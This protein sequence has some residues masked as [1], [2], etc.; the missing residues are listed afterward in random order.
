MANHLQLVSSAATH[1]AQPDDAQGPPLGPRDEYSYRMGRILLG[2][3]SVVVGASAAVAAGLVYA[4][5]TIAAAIGPVGQTTAVGMMMWG[6]SIATGV[7]LFGVTV[8]GMTCLSLF[9]FVRQTYTGE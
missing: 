4:T 5:A 6:F 3:F 9:Y 8:G 7:L 1:L 2:A